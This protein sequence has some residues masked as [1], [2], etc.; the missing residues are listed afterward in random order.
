MKNI[1]GKIMKI[2][3]HKEGMD[4]ALKEA[5]KALKKGEVPVGAIIVDSDGYILA[6]AHNETLKN[7]DPTSHAE[8][9]CIKRACQK[10]KN[11]RLIGATMYVTLEPC[12]MCAGA[13]VHAR[14]KNLIFALADGKAGGCESIF[15]IVVNNNLNHKVNI[16]STIME[17]EAKDLLKKFFSSKREKLKDT[18]K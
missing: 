1:T 2:N 5:K 10:I 8:I 12:A 15:N 16:L 4:L 6:K 14:I 7:T 3:N 13:I 9:V 11:E 17:D 18:Y